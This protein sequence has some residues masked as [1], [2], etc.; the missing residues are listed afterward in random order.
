MIRIFE[1][2][3]EKYDNELDGWIAY[4]TETKRFALRL[5]E[6]YTGKHPDIMFKI[7]HSKGYVNAEEMH[8]QMFVEARIVPPNRHNSEDVLEYHGLKEYDEFGIMLGTKGR[9]CMDNY[10]IEEIEIGSKEYNELV[11]KFAWT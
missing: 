8:A 4:N 9:G 10:C 1:I 6:D 3:N 7:L 11:N 5:L 2:L